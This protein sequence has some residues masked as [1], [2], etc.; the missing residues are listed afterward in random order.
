MISS[1]LQRQIWLI[2]VILNSSSDGIT[3]QEIN[4]K[5]LNSSLNDTGEDLPKRTFFSQINSILENFGLEI[6]CDVKSGYRY[7][8][9][10]DDV[11]YGSIK[12][13]LL[14]S[15]LISN[16]ISI[17]PD[18]S[19][20]VQVTKSFGEA[21]LSPILGAILKNRMLKI[22]RYVDMT[23]LR[24]T[25]PDYRNCPDSDTTEMIAPYGLYYRGVWFLIGK[26]QRDQQLH[27]FDITALKEIDEL[28]ETFAF[29]ENFDLG[30]FVENYDSSEALMK[31]TGVI[32]DGS[33]FD[34]TYG[35]I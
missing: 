8:L 30:E 11:E 20:R 12:K 3:F 19:K 5:W 27:I 21:N 2:D 33:V 28:T 34:I 16:V 24:E 15:F 6:K 23:S 18:I 29:P 31:S 4:S 26:V 1:A 35:H 9:S 7:S 13:T 22:R 32:D 14:N 10:F 25:N 17:R